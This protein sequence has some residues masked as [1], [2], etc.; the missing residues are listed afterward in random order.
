MAVMVLLRV[1]VAVTVLLV[2]AVTV[3]SE[4]AGH[5]LEV[6]IGQIEQ[7]I[8]ATELLLVDV[9]GNGQ[10]L[11]LKPGVAE[12]THSLDEE[13]SGTVEV[14]VG[15]TVVVTSSVVVVPTV[16]VTSS[17]DEGDSVNVVQEVDAETLALKKT[18]EVSTRMLSEDEIVTVVVPV[19][20]LLVEQSVHGTKIVVVLVTTLP[21]AVEAGYGVEA[22]TLERGRVVS[23]RPLAAQKAS[24]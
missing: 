12:S 13:L 17:K 20:M 3:L 6:D 22:E 9:S 11:E 18:V 7:G 21:A 5:P 2:V 8:V 4:Q 10:M 16:S 23:S 1:A 15:V 19:T 14:T 24:I